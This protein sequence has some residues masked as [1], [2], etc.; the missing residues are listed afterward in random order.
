M[1]ISK[2]WVFWKNQFFENRLKRTEKSNI[3]A[4]LKKGHS[5]KMLNPYRGRS[6]SFELWE[7]SLMKNHHEKNFT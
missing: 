3:Y 4:V 6:R 7:G 2:G 1:A 5:F